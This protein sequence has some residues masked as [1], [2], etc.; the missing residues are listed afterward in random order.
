MHLVLH[1][2]AQAK[3]ERFLAMSQARLVTVDA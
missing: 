3:R 2:A 1:H